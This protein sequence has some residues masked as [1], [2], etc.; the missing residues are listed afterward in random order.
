MVGYLMLLATAA[1]QSSGGSPPP[2]SCF[3]GD[4]A[5]TPLLA[6]VRQSAGGGLAPVADGDA[7][8]LVVPPQGG[9]VLLVGVRALNIDGCPLTL[10]ASLVLSTGAVAAFERRPVNLR[11]AADGWLQPANPSGLADFANLPACPIAG[12]HQSIDGAP[13]QLVL[14]AED[15]AGRQAHAVVTV[16]PTCDVAGSAGTCRCLCAAGYVLGAPCP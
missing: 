6:P 8:S 16:V 12:L 1:C 11:P 13:A 3:V 4:Q 15:Q 9:E 5:A 10:S 2:S 7:L 14:D